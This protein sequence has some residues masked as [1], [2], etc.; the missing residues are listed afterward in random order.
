VH[1]VIA[2][3]NDADTI[4]AVATRAYNAGYRQMD[5]YSPFPIHG[6]AEAI[7]FKKTSVPL[8]V[9]AGGL[10]GAVSGF[11]MQYIASVL[12][13]PYI[14]S[15]RPMLSWPMFIPITFELGILCAAFA[16]LL[17]ML[18]LNDLPKPYHPVFNA[19]GF[20]RASRDSFFLCI[21]AGDAKYD[22]SET[23][24]FLEGLGGQNVQ[25]VES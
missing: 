2:E 20:E 25:V 4:V 18:F 15:G 7:G 10:F 9:L 1:G 11:A 5:A 14:I 17:S 6:L 8:F 16:A 22:E 23:R 24:A 19:E 13:Y 3:F 21:E 12:H